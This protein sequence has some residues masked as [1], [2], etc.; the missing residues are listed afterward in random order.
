MNDTSIRKHALV[1]SLFCEVEAMIAANYER[2]LNNQS[3][4]YHEESFMEISDKLRA[5]AEGRETQF[6][7]EN[8]LSPQDIE[9]EIENLKENLK[10]VVEDFEDYRI[11]TGEY[12][13][14]RC[15]R[16]TKR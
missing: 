13:K 9:K 5:I 8:R 12:F 16:E 14:N 10:K 3:L 2:E 1:I 7:G 11:K 15:G 4:A 6:S